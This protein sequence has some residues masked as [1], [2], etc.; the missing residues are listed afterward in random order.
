MCAEGEESGGSY[1]DDE[2]EEDDP[3]LEMMFDRTPESDAIQELNKKEWEA[4]SWLSEVWKQL[5]VARGL[6]KVYGSRFDDEVQRREE[7]ES[8]I[9]AEL[10]AIM[11]ERDDLE[12]RAYLRAGTMNDE[13]E[14]IL[15]ARMACDEPPSPPT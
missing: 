12:D 3:P 14:A 1:Y 8:E 6:V 10:W 13:E 2:W 11:Q 7:T 15:E 9:L 4:E 5:R